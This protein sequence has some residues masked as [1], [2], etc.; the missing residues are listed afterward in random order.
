MLS[1]IAVIQACCWSKI[2]IPGDASGVVD[3][4]NPDFFFRR[5]EVAVQDIPC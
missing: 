1:V 4:R 3:Q 5:L 2:V